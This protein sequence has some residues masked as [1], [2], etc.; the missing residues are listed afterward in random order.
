MT[1]E[2][3]RLID[4]RELAKRDLEELGEQVEAGEIDAET[5]SRLRAGYE[6]ELRKAEAALGD[7]P[8][9]D[10]PQPAAP[11]P[12]PEPSTVV[13][14]PESAGRSPRRVV[15]GSAVLLVS[16]TLIIFFAARDSEPEATGSMGAGAMGE[17]TVD[18]GAV[19]N[20]DLE[21]V[22][23]ANPE[24]TSMRMALAD[25]YFEAEQYGASLEHYLFIADNA[26]DLREQSKALARVGWMAY[27]TD[28][29]EAAAEYMESSLEADPSNAEAILFQGF[30]TMYGL[31]DPA[32][33]IPQLEAALA[34]PNLSDNVIAQV[35]DAL[36]EARGGSTP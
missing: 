18:P 7:L 15:V 27:I 35:N 10:A 21:A 14:R 2:R 24:I 23:A 19:S 22:V 28:Q 31:E 9:S 30:V 17:L 1:S 20:E 12:P 11:Q 6:Q 4:R 26:E 5:A 33:A 34:L 25:R 29:A 3:D 16:L 36:A 13:K 8:P 32:A